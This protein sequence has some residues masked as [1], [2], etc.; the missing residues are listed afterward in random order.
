[1]RQLNIEV[2]QAWYFSVW[3][4]SEIETFHL[5]LKRFQAIELQVPENDVIVLL[6]NSPYS[7]PDFTAG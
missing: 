1:M 3:C 2:A 6:L 4:N 5:R 7:T